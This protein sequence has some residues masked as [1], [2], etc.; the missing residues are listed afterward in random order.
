MSE[1]PLVSIIVPALNEEKN[2][3]PVYEALLPIWEAESGR[4]RFELIFTDNHSSDRTFELAA[5]LAQQ[6]CRVRVFRFSRNF[7][8][9]QSILTG[10]RKARGA[11]VVQI[12]CDLQDPPAMIRDFLRKWEAGYHVVYGI[13]RK[14]KEGFAITA[15]R[16]MFYALVDFLSEYPLP[17]QAGDFRLVS[18]AIIDELNRVEEPQPYIRGIIAGL[19]FNQI[20][21]PYDREE[22]KR[23]ESK[24]SMR[25][26]LALGVDGIL[27]T[28]VVPLRVATY[29]G[30][31]V[32]VVTMIAA[33]YYLVLALVYGRRGWPSGW[34]TV[35]ICVL[36]S[37]GL[38]ALFLGIIGEYLGR[39]YKQS[40][41]RSM[42]IIEQAVERL[43]ACESDADYRD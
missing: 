26:L 42:T 18:R 27:S 13:R 34:A 16:G 17:R 24:F 9:Q 40:K 21:I 15:L 20:G 5:E 37:L 28:S 22:R 7:G 38:N 19:G 11:A 30:L 6:D 33:L 29:L 25:K 23:G 31:S 43:G 35:A 4:Y 39:L 12:D 2:I 8:F 32:S 36:F 3:R 41:R 14:R 10:Y 1:Q